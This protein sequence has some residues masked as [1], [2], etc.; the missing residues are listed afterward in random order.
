[1]TVDITDEAKLDRL[2]NLG[3]VSLQLLTE[4]GITTVGELRA[5]GA[6]EA[7]H[8]LKF[9]NPKRVTLNFLYALNAGLAGLPWQ[10]ITPEMKQDWRREAGLEEC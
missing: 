9:T 3:P 10:A 5:L 2:P 6:A 1:M 8:R 4:A 7:Y